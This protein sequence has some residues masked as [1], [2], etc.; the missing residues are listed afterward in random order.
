MDA[1]TVAGRRFLSL[2]ALLA[3]GAMLNACG[4]LPNMFGNGEEEDENEQFATNEQGLT[5]GTERWSVK[6][7]T[8]ADASR[9]NLTSVTTSIGT[10]V[11][12]ARP[13]SLPSNNRVSPVELTTY[14]L[15]NVT[16]TKYKA[17]TDS[18]YHIVVSSGGQTMIVEIPNPGCVGSGSP[19]LSR[20]QSAKSAFDAHY[21]ATSTFKTSSDTVTI[22]GVGFWD[23]N[24]GQTGVAP[25]AIELHP[26]TFFCTGLNC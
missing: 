14:R 26:V 22:I 4:S 19:F 15:R 21:S 6:T 5:C 7:G 1:P 13:A 16:M 8:D 23:F 20:I 18:D 25:N 3:L 10:L 11:G 9:V 2:A 12:Y 17:E 24:H